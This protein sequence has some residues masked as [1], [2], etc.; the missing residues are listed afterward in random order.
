MY[1]GSPSDFEKAIASGLGNQTSQCVTKPLK[2]ILAI[3]F[4]VFTIFA[5]IVIRT[6]KEEARV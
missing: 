4:S 5:N 1:T 3:S 6:S 2:P